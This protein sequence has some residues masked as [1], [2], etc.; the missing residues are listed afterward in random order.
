MTWESWVNEVLAIAA[1]RNIEI[2]LQYPIPNWATFSWKCRDGSNYGTAGAGAE[3]ISLTTPEQFTWLWTCDARRVISP[4]IPIGPSFGGS[5]GGEK[6]VVSR[7]IA[8]AV[9]AA[10][11]EL[12]KK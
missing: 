5:E 4:N 1:A 2:T 8:R 7:R 12:F 10:L 3:M 11:K 9:S 6:R